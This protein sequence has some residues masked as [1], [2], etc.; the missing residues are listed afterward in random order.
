MLKSKV[1]LNKTEINSLKNKIAEMQAL[2][3]ELQK[4]DDEIEDELGASEE[5]Y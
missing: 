2:I 5:N 4:E 3:L 1:A